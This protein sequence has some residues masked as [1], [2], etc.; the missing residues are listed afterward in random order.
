VPPHQGQEHLWDN[1]SGGRIRTYDQRI[2]S[3]LRYR[4]ATPDCL[5]AIPYQ[6]ASALATP[7]SAI[8]NR[9]FFGGPPRGYGQ[10]RSTQVLALHMRAGALHPA[11]HHGKPIA[12]AQGRLSRRH[13]RRITIFHH[14]GGRSRDAD[15]QS[16]HD[17]KGRLF[18]SGRATAASSRAHGSFASLVQGSCPS[19]CGPA[20]KTSQVIR[21][22]V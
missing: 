11:T 2:N 19:R 14:V 7:P 15:H 22:G 18:L 17:R 16:R 4:C 6:P 20:D 10:L 13:L 1:G 8:G 21:R 9:G 5:M 3:P 12:P